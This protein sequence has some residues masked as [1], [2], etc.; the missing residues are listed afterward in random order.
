M[1]GVTDEVSVYSLVNTLTEFTAVN[2]VRITVDSESVKA[3]GTVPI[4]G[5]LERRPDLTDSERAGEA[6]E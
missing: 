2:K 1:E 5:F 6:G 4:D 3:Y